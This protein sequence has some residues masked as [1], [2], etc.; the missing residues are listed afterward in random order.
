[1]KSGC[2]VLFRPIGL[3]VRKR[4]SPLAQGL[5]GWFPTSRI[6]LGVPTPG[7]AV[8]FLQPNVCSVQMSF[9]ELGNLND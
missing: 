5:R 6:E 2:A 9:S 1:M 7:P 8:E 3:E 4:V